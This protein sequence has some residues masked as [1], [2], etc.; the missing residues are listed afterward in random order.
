MA[1]EDYI[2][3]TEVDP[4]GKIDITSSKITVNDIARADLAYV[5]KEGQNFDGDFT[6]QVEFKTVD[7]EY[8]WGAI[9]Q[10]ANVIDGWRSFFNNINKGLYLATGNL[11]AIFL[12]ESHSGGHHYD[13]GEFIDVTDYYLTIV[14]DETIGSYGQLQCF[15]YIDASRT[16]LDDTLTIT[17]N[18]KQNFDTIYGFNNDEWPGS[19]TWE[20]EVRNLE[21][22]EIPGIVI[23]RRRM[24]EY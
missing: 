3:Y 2:T 18:E 9:W 14:R 20:G 11:T 23:L 4:T 15:I 22:G 10:V 8:A 6:H 5:Y 7:V 12:G 13:V 21:L 17:L 19:D 16:I 24:E 1:F